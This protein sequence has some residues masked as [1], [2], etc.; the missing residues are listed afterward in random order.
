MALRHPFKL[1]GNLGTGWHNEGLCGGLSHLG[2]R[3]EKVGEVFGRQGQ[4]KAFGPARKGKAM[5]MAARHVDR[6][7]RRDRH[8]RAIKRQFYMPALQ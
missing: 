2:L 8:I 4:D 6:H 3:P 5:N 1:R 7:R